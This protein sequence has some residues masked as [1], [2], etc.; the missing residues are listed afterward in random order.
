MRRRPFQTNYAGAIYGTILSMA[1]ITTASK[2]PSIGPI[3]I[4]GWAAATAIVFFIAHVYADIV[5]AGFARP[6]E[7]KDLAKSAVR[8]EWP[9]VQGSLIPAAAM[10]LA[11]LGVVSTEKA[12]YVAMYVGVVVL[13][14]AGLFIG[15]RENLGWMRMLTIGAIN[16]F[17]GL[18]IVLLKIFVH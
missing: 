1:V 4:A 7:A 8:K 17:I 3:M 9:M 18:L 15:S 11:P 12:T 2:D 14:L 5:A 13:F 10:L 6:S 16:A